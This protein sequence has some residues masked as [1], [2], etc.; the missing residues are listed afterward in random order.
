[1]LDP[2]TWARYAQGLKTLCVKH[3]LHADPT[4]TADISSVLRTPGTHNRK[5]GAPR[6]VECNPKFL[7]IE[8]YAIERFD[9]LAANAG[10]QRPAKRANVLPFPF[11]H[12]PKH[13]IG[14][15][16]RRRIAEALQQ[17]AAYEPTSGAPIA[18]QCGQ[19]R[20]LRDKKGCLPEPLWYAALGVL[21]FCEDGDELAHAWSSGFERY[22]VRET[23]ER[24]DRA[25]QLTGATT[26]AFSLAQPGDLRSMPALGQD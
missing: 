5:S 20:A 23:R 25:H 7:E 10:L 14:R 11:D 16:P 1:M 17:V 8:P 26:C 19:V 22:T 24:L 18:E 4:R 15:S 21:A 6:A 12:A 9:I 13:L 3:S 2:E